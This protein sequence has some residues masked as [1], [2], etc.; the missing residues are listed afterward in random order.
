MCTYAKPRV[1]PI[2][3]PSA[4]AKV[5]VEVVDGHH[6]HAAWQ[7]VVQFLAHAA[8]KHLHNVGNGWVVGHGL[9]FVDIWGFFAQQFTRRLEI[10]TRRVRISTRRVDFATSHA[11]FVFYEEFP[12]KF[13]ITIYFCVDF[14][15]FAC[16]FQM[17]GLVLQ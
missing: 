9:H 6:A 5:L 14:L 1:K 16:M 7:A 13:F 3:A 2:V 4:V 17:F 11:H 12:G 15:H 8:F 10:S